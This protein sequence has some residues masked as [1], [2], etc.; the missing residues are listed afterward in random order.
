[1]R[2]GKRDLFERM[3]LWHWL[4]QPLRDSLAEAT[5]DGRCW[6]F[7]L[8]QEVELVHAVQRPLIRP[9]IERMQVVRDLGQTRAFPAFPARCSLKS[10]DRLDLLAK[11]HEPRDD[12]TAPS[13]TSDARDDLAFQVKVTDDADYTPGAGGYADHG[14]PADEG[15]GPDLIGIN[16]PRRDAIAEK[17]HEFKDT[18]YRRVEYR[19][20][21]ATRYRENLPQAILGDPPSEAGIAL[22][23]LPTV[24]WVPSSAPPP[25]P[26]VLY[27][28]PTF[29]WVRSRD[30]D[31]TDRSW[32]RGGGLS[33]YLDRPLEHDG[34][35]RGAGGGSAAHGLRR[36]SGGGCQVPQDRHPVGQRPDLRVALRP[37][38][39]AGAGAI[40]A[41][42]HAGRSVRGPGS[43]RMRRRERRTSRPAASRQR[44]GCPGGGAPVEIAPHDVQ[45]D[46]TRRP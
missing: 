31:G 6:L 14:L 34:L 23:G 25:A 40:S 39:H 29:G 37:G 7:G 38:P 4:N 9:R 33:V 13:P 19:L 42:A 8:W 24:G 11:W 46:A 1:M 15:M 27:V 26:Q 41:G 10:T 44:S 2:I 18:R 35:R 32:R 21:G 12:P 28:V 43:R 3:G 45:Y 16:R 5:I 22:E 30:A 17:G 20:K 36:G